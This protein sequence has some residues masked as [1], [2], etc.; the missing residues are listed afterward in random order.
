MR[1]AGVQR[2]SQHQAT[3]L[4]DPFQQHLPDSAD[5]VYA[6]WTPHERA[7]VAAGMLLRVVGRS[8][9]KVQYIGLMLKGTN[10][11]YSHT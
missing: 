4:H 3:W 10:Q 7:N 2:H 8:N 5:P 11:S 6:Y 9:Y 1:A